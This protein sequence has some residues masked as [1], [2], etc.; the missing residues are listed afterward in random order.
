M[1]PRRDARLDGPYGLLERRSDR[2]SLAAGRDFRRRLWL[3]LREDEDECRAAA[4]VARQPQVTIHA[5][6]EISADCEPKAEAFLCLR[7]RSI[8]LDKGLED[9]LAAGLGN[10][11]SGVLDRDL[12][13]R[14][15]NRRRPESDTATSRCKANCVR[16]QV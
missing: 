13:F 14:R 6:R 7:E 9:L 1:F 16:Q 5:S 3:A 4:G 11:R 8:E 15:S 12:D 2:G 10:A